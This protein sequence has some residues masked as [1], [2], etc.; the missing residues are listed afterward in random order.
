[1]QE[2]IWSKI[3]AYLFRV[4]GGGLG[5]AGCTAILL[6]NPLHKVFSSFYGITFLLIFGGM[7]IYSTFSMIS[8]LT[9]NEQ[10]GSN[11][12]GSKSG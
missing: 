7:G 9:G 11:S 2:D 6:N 10:S 5:F 12:S 8:A 4:L 3:D 1:M